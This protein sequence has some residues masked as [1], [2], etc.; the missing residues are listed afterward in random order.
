MA[1]KIEGGL[2]RVFAFLLREQKKN[3]WGG[4]LIRVLGYLLNKSFR[5]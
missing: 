2:S 1:K 4:E 3:F 5:W